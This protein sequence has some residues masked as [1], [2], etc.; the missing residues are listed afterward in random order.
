MI[1]HS[2]IDFL[3]FRDDRLVL[4]QSFDLFVMTSTLEGI[5]RCLMEATAM[6]IPVAAYNIA[7]IEF[8]INKI[9]R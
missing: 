7:G 5:P 8:T 6:G 4:L 9:N 3:G 1:S 2:K